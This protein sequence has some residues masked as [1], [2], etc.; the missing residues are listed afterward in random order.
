M[1]KIIERRNPTGKVVYG[2]RWQDEAGK[3]CKRFSRTWTKER[4]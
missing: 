1:G 2:I 4:S 3:D